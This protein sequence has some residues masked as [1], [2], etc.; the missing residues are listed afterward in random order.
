[1]AQKV[2]ITLTCDAHETEVPGTE[3]VLFGLDGAA[4]EIDLCADHAE[5]LRE[6]VEAFVGSARKA[7]RGNSAPRKKAAKSDTDVADIREW[8]K[9]NGHAVSERGRIS[10][11][12]KEAYQAAH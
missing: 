6:A 3:T 5:E 9:A 11:T 7:G 10:S 8:A 4:Y 2:Q 12:V 1:M